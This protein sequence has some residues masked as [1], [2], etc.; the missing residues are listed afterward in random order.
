[1][2]YLSIDGD[3]GSPPLRR[4]GGVSQCPNPVCQGNWCRT[5]VRR[6]LFALPTAGLQQHVIATAMMATR[7]I[8]TVL[9]A[10][11]TIMPFFA[12]FLHECKHLRDTPRDLS[13]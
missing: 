4:H 8:V 10:D 11:A 5:S 1:M 13:H 12:C 2:M 6:A 7:G 3:N 9:R